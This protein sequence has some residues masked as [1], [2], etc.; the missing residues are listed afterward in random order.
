MNPGKC[1]E[2]FVIKIQNL[3]S[4]F[5]T[6]P[7]LLHDVLGL[8]ILEWVA[9]AVSHFGCSD[10]SLFFE[11]FACLLDYL[12]EFLGWKWQIHVDA[13]YLE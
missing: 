9:L 3:S 4:V 12:S 8:G 7:S 2:I 1:E 6:L 5:P 11:F 13:Q 10:S